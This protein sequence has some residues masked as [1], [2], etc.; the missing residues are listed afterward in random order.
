MS[1]PVKTA[2]ILGAG[3]GTRMR[4]LTNQLPKPLCCSASCRSIMLDRLAGAGVELA[5][6]N[7]HYRADQL[8]EHLKARKSPRIIISD[9]REGLLDTGGGV[10]RALPLIG[11]GPFYIHNSD[12]VS[13]GGLGANLRRMA[14]IWNPRADG[15]PDAAGDRHHPVGYSGMGDFEMTPDGILRRRKERQV[16]PFIFSGVS[17]AT[18][19]SSGSPQPWRVLSRSTCYGIVPWPRAGCTGCSRKA[20]DA[21]RRSA[22]AGGG[23][24][25]DQLGRSTPERDANGG[26][27]C[28]RAP[29]ACS[30]CCPDPHS[31]T[32][33]PRRSQQ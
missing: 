4:P 12:A 8:I 26:S 1:F 22:I 18:P 2:M 21:C 7:V 17:T 25:D 20:S 10:K 13:I 30:R 33:W 19:A 27:A 9:E 29:D 28:R 32:G 24:K 23:G 31:S 11:K 3:L 16:A 6:V 5:V 15:Q 14:E